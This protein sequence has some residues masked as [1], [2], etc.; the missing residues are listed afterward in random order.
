AVRPKK[1]LVGISAFYAKKGHTIGAGQ[2]LFSLSS[3]R[4]RNER[5]DTLFLGCSKSAGDLLRVKG[6]HQFFLH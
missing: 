4:E 2:S 3:S 5:L 1:V 6:A